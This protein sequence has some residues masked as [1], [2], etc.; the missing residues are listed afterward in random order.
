M[1]QSVNK[2]HRTD[3]A[4][5]KIPDAPRRRSDVRGKK[6]KWT[7]RMPRT[8]FGRPYVV[9]ERFSSDITAALVVKYTIYAVISLFLILLKTTFFSRFRPFGATPDILIV[10]VAAIALFEGGRAGALFGLIIGFIADTLGGVGVVLLPLPYM[11]LGY[12]CGTVADEYYR[13]SW[14]LFLIFDI[15]AAVLRIFVSIAYVF[16]TWHSFSISTLF[17]Q[18]LIP[19]FWSTLSVSFVPAVMLVPVYLIFKKR[20][21]EQE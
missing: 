21:K 1:K 12:I 15:C 8:F 7:L 6:R 11:L 17:S 2:S 13:R 9:G 14:L 18:V 19:E 5:R 3:V 4:M 10:A 16:L 20:G